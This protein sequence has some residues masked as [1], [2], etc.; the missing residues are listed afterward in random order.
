MNNESDLW[1]CE[2]YLGNMINTSNNTDPIF[3]QWGQYNPSWSPLAAMQCT[4]SDP[5]V[6]YCNVSQAVQG[7]A[8]LV[9]DFYSNARGASMQYAFAA[10]P[11][12]VT[13]PDTVREELQQ[14]P[15]ARFASR[16]LGL[17]FPS[18]PC[19]CKIHP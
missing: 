1:N 3:P 17:C 13:L 19:S 15:N 12:S 7:N 10:A 11:S 18:H 4:S 2:S 5:R 14:K 9:Q 16:M 8:A 6:G